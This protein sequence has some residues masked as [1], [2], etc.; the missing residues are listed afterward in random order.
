LLDNFNLITYYLNMVFDI[1]PIAMTIE[2][3]SPVLKTTY[4]YLGTDGV[5]DASGGFIRME[6]GS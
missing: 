1:R 4:R 5:N 3:V 2:T 6:G